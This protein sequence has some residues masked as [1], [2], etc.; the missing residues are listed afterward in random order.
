MKLG[1]LFL[2]FPLLL[3]AEMQ[4]QASTLP[5]QFS[6]SMHLT[7]EKI[8]LDQTTQLTIEWKAPKEY[9]VDTEKI[10]EQLIWSA[11]P[12]NLPLTIAHY[13]QTD[14]RL[15]IEL[16]PLQAGSIPLSLLT[17]SF[18]KEKEKAVEVKTP[19]WTLEVSP[20]APVASD[21]LNPAPLIELTPEFP[22]KL[23]LL[24]REKFIDNSDRQRQEQKKILQTLQAH[25]FPWIL[26]FIFLGVGGLLAFIYLTQREWFKPKIKT[27]PGLTQNQQIDQRLKELQKQV[28]QPQVSTAA[29]Y[30]QLTQF[31]DYLIKAKS[32]IKTAHYTTQEWETVFPIQIEIN[33]EEFLKFL[34]AADQVKFAKTQPSLEDKKQALHYIEKI[35]KQ[36]KF[37]EIK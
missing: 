13:Q 7:S 5:S 10:L 34:T 18:Q 31:V 16:K 22:L 30:H 21:Q 11:N 29:F 20:L 32:G 24:N 25:T 19:F 8:S 27:Q 35:V 28:N 4:W 9:T 6:L 3:A 14:Q 23:S 26:V 12:L 17:F 36:L 33:R 15:T 1:F 37:T 2:F